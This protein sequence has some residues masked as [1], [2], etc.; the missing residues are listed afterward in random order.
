MDYV[1]KY[2]LVF[3]VFNLVLIIWFYVIVLSDFIVR[4]SLLKILVNRRGKI[5]IDS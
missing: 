3:I 2:V 1:W 5:F 4:L